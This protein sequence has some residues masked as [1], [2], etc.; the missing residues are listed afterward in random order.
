[1]KIKFNGRAVSITSLEQ[2][3]AELN[4]YDL[5]PEFELW[6]SGGIHPSMSMLRSGE[7]AWLMYMRN[8]DDSVHSKGTYE[9]GAVC[10][11]RLGNGQMGECPLSW[12]I[13]VEQCYKAIAYFYVNQGSAPA[14]IEWN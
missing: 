12:C 4:Q 11:F 3:G 6:I 13:E 9:G 5:V 1:M 7:R 10:K 2:L 8:E 14:W